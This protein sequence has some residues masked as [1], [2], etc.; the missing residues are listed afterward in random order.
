MMATA[1]GT[2]E[3]HITLCLRDDSDRLITDSNLK[4]RVIGKMDLK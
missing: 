2:K 1:F 3:H 4:H